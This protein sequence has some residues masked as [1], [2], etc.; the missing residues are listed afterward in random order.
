MRFIYFRPGGIQHTAQVAKEDAGDKVVIKHGE[1]DLTKLPSTLWS[2]SAVR[3][4]GRSFPLSLVGAF[5]L[6]N[7]SI[8]PVFAV[9]TAAGMVAI[10]LLLVVC[11]DPIQISLVASQPGTPFQHPMAMWQGFV[12]IVL[13]A[14]GRRRRSPTSPRH[15]A[16]GLPD[17]SQNIWTVSWKWPASISF[18]RGDGP[19]SPHF[20]RCA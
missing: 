9:F 16:A 17:R 7:P 19:P 1:S 18:S 13:C 8:P 4:F 10:T 11:G 5:N 3:D 20:H 15:E 12:G 2:L 6:W 14:F